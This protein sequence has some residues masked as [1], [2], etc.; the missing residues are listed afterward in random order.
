VAGALVAAV[1]LAASCGGQK[2]L[3][4]GYD[5]DGMTLSNG[6]L[7]GDDVH[8]FD[9]C[10]PILGSARRY[11]RRCSIPSGADRLWIGHGTFAETPRAL[12]TEWGNTR[13]SLWVDGRR[14]DLARFGTADR[15]L[16]AFP[17][18]GGL[19]VTLREWR[20][21]LAP[22]PAGE[23]E[24]HYRIEPKSGGSPTDAVWTFDAPRA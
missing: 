21:R 5:V 2:A 4:P 15:M 14:V 22:V 12:D 23:H 24:V 10:D 3:E 9:F 19:T 7:T 20:V 6:A 16:F 18:A 11:E 8:F 13:W 17:P 1:L